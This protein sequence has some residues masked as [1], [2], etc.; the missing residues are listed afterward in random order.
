MAQKKIISIKE[1]PTPDTV[2]NLHIQDNHNYFSNDILVKNCHTNKAASLIKI[3][4]MM[5]K[6]PIRIGLT[7]SMSN[8]PLYDHQ[9]IGCFGPVIQYVS[10][11][12]LIKQG[13]SSPI[14]IKS[15][16]LH[17]NLN[18]TMLL[19]YQDEVSYL[20]NHS[21][22][23]EFFVNLALSL[24]G[25]SFLMFNRIDH[26]KLMYE[27]IKNKADCPVYY[28]DGQTPAI[29]R[30][31]LKKLINESEHCIV[32]ASTVFTTGVNIKSIN[33][34]VFTHPTKSRIR[35]L[36][37]IGRGLRKSETKNK[38]VLYDVY[39][40]LCEGLVNTTLKHA[41]ERDKLYKEEKFP[42]KEY[43]VQLNNTIM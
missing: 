1:I 4:N 41:R 35:V 42:V 24:K 11:E 13:F 22:R 20:L 23:T 27:S 19:E 29:E 37:S 25:N 32:L 10:N 21:K 38:L 33:N 17:H 3:M 26:G 9:I 12:D 28:V 2:Y 7:G 40:V 43:Q 8:V 6:T 31:R 14:L 30:D 5:Y 34:I 36:Q 39:D 18:M 15:I 16:E